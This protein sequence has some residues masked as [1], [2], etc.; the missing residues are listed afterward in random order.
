VGTVGLTFNNF[1]ARN[2]T[3]FDK[4]RPL[5]VGDGQRFSLSAQA[6]GKA[7]QSYNVSFTEPWLGGHHRN[8]FT[9]SLSHS[10]SRRPNSN[11][12][13]TEDF[14]L[15]QSGITLSLGRQLEW[16][17]NYFTL[18][19][20]LSFL[21][22][23]YSNYLIGSTALPPVGATNSFIF[24]TTLAR[25]S[26]DNP[27]F[28][29]GGS[30]VS[31]SLSLTPPYSLFRDA[32]FVN[33]IN[34]R[35]KWLELYKVMFDSKFYLKLLGSSKPTG[36]SLVLEARAHLGFIGAYNKN[37]PTGPFERFFMGGAGLAGG[38]NSYVLGQEI[39]G[40]R[41]YPDNQVTPPLYSLRNTQNATSIEGG[42]VYDKFVME[43]RYPITTSQTA[44]IYALSFAEA[45]NNWNN[46][47]EFNPFKS[48]RSAGFG[49][50]I[51]MPAFGLI[52]LNWAYGF[53]TLPGATQ[54]SGAQFHFTIGQQI[55]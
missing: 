28:P 1:S 48:Y 3:H 29:T 30:S 33:D 18:T 55:R 20:S 31:L 25:N 15:K 17:D 19:N 7:F 49:A 16:P 42:I 11:Y 8:S 21:V 32:N 13:F 4:W 54:K 40:L 24:N 43:L 12:Q 35:Y 9:V 5:P 51:F 10:I 27:M 47:Y 50:R 39:V 6:N 38:F 52:G 41:G 34:Q 45:G 46:F 44:T 53:D 14:S 37:L 23:N 22:Y 2:V 36:R 26:I